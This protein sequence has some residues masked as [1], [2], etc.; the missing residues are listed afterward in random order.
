MLSGEKQRV[1]RNYSF[2]DVCEWFAGRADLILLLFDPYKLDISDEFKAVISAL[3]GHDDKVLFSVEF[4]VCVFV[5]KRA[6][7]MV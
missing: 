2:A 7:V 3:R 5:S 6:H 1:E 4:V